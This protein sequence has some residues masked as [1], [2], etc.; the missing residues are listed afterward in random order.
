M[1]QS[2]FLKWFFSLALV[3][4]LSVPGVAQAEMTVKLT[5]KTSKKISVALR[6]KN[7][8]SDTWVTQAWWNVEP[9]KVRTITLDS[10]NTVAY[11]YATAGSSWWGAKPGEKGASQLHIV[12]DKFLVKDSNKPKGK[13]LRQV[14]FRRTDAKNRVFSISF[15]G[16]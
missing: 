12:G 9:M 11:F 6:Y 8:V 2:G 3:M 16:S 14:W 10:N 13:N 1:K 5:N 15:Q 7:S 4:C